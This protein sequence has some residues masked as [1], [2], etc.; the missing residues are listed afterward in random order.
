MGCLFMEQ[1]KFQDHNI[2]IENRAKLNVSGVCDVVSFDEE[3]ILLKT[4]MG[5]ITV[6]G[7]NLRITSFDN[8][9]GD[10]IAE[11]KIHAVVY[12]SDD[13]ESVGFFSKLFR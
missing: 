7:E 4:V 6:K 10:L 12:M 5:K 3:T 9:I 13:K 11:G 1:S 2:I 8:E